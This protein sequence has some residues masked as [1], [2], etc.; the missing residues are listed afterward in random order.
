MSVATLQL[1]FM[2]WPPTVD[3]DAVPPPPLTP[4]RPRGTNRYRAHRHDRGRWKAP[5]AV[6]RHRSP[7]DTSR[8]ASGWR[9]DAGSRAPEARCDRPAVADR[10]RGTTA[11]KPD[12]HTGAAIGRRARPQRSVGRSAIQDEHHAVRRSGAELRASS[13]AVA[14]GAT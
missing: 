2:A 8:E 9:S 4:D 11:R 7:R 12:E 3:R 1:D 5:G 10:S 6:A 14:R 13:D